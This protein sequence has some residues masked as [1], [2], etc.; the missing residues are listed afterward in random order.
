MT[1]TNLERALANTT[2]FFAIL[3]LQAITIERAL[4]GPA[5]RWWWTNI[6]NGK[7][8]RR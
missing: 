1:L 8:T 2:I 6:K 5:A 3:T 4:D 7:R